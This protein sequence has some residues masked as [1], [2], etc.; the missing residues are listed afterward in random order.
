MQDHT[1]PSRIIEYRK[2]PLKTIQD[3]TRPKMSTKGQ[4][5][6]YQDHQIVFNNIQGEKNCTKD[7]KSLQDHTR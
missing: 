1:R 6:A 2:T 4:H 5:Y 7:K 3:H